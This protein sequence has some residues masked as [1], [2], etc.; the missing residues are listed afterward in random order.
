[1]IEKEEKEWTR[2]LAKQ[3][4]ELGLTRKDVVER[5]VSLLIEAGVEEHQVLHAHTIL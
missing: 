2:R 3:L 4:L 1:M 5:T